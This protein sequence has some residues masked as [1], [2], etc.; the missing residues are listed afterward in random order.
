LYCDRL[1][2]FLSGLLQLAPKLSLSELLSGVVC[3]RDVYP[4]VKA[5]AER[6]YALDPESGDTCTVLG[7]LRAWFEHRWDEADSTAFPALPKK[8][9]KLLLRG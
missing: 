3:S 8:P 2:E 9:S 6:G 5:N 4:E 7:A 1:F